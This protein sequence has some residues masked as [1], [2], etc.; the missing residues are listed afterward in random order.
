MDR[1]GWLIFILFVICFVVLGGSFIHSC[2]N[3]AERGLKSVVEEVWEGQ[4]N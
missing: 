2:N 3:I 4:K 1:E